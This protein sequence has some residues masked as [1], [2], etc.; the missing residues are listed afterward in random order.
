MHSSLSGF[1]LSMQ[2]DIHMLPLH[3]DA[4]SR[5]HANGKVRA[6]GDNKQPVSCE[7]HLGY[8]RL[9]LPIRVLISI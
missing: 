7:W 2:N 8:G 9:N 4:T 5:A 3:A 6:L 1:S